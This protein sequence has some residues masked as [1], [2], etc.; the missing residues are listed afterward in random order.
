MNKQQLITNKL[1]NTFEGYIHKNSEKPLYA[2]PQNKTLT[3]DPYPNQSGL[4]EVSPSQA[5]QL[6]SDWVQESLNYYGF[7]NAYT[8]LDNAQISIEDHGYITNLPLFITND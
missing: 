4:I 5:Y 8:C 7:V 2:I 3:L 6:L 1:W